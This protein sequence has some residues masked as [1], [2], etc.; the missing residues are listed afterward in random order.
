M[1]SKGVVLLYLILQG[2]GVGKHLGFMMLCAL[3]PRVSGLGLESRIEPLHPPVLP[4]HRVDPPLLSPRTTS[5]G[6][7]PL[8][9]HCHSSPPSQLSWLFHRDLVF[10][11]LPLSSRVIASHL[12]TTREVQPGLHS[13]SASAPPPPAYNYGSYVPQSSPLA[14]HHR[15]PQH[16]PA[17]LSPAITSINRWKAETGKV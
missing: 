17:T 9:A 3:F 2:Q 13:P 5:L 1:Q 6:D 4:G 11:S 7:I 12:P 15:P 14:P 16:R 8:W 10:L